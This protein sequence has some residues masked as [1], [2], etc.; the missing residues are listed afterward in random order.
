M[1]EMFGYTQSEMETCFSGHIERFAEEYNQSS[2]QIIAELKRHYNGYRFSEKDVRVYNPF[3]V[4]R[5]LSEHAF[6]NYWFE[7]GTP[8]FLVN[9][10]RERVYPLPKIEHMEADEET[11]STYEIDNLKPEALLFQTGYV[12]IKEVEDFIYTFTYPNKEVK[13]AFQKHLL[14]SYIKDTVQYSKVLRISSHLQKERLDEFMEA[15]SSVFAAIPYSIESK[16]DEAYFHTIF[17]LAVSGY[18]GSC[19][20]RSADQRRAD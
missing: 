8:T 14:F 20:E 11:F 13:L 7:T 1:R 18:G 4:L 9:L 12:T 6:K 5:A 3:S 17:Y 15:I 10:L 2:E 19:R 16:R